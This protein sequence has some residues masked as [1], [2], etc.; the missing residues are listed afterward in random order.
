MRGPTMNEEKTTEELN[1]Q[2]PSDLNILPADIQ[3]VMQKN[4]YFKLLCVNEAQSRVIESLQNTCKVLK[5]EIDILNQSKEEKD[6]T[7]GKG[8]IRK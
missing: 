6:A 8:N 2:V 4:E 7:N 1:G 3:S 5:N